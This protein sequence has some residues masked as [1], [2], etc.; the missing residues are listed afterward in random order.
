TG[1]VDGRVSF[2]LVADEQ[3]ALWCSEHRRWHQRLTIDHHDLR[4]ATIDRSN[5]ARARCAEV[6]GH[7]QRH[8]E[9]LHRRRS[10]RAPEA[11]ALGGFQRIAPRSTL[12][13]RCTHLLTIAPRTCGNCSD[14]LPVDR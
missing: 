1:R 10:A 13:A 5:R 3:R 6:D 7:V 14:P 2:G 11:T 4:F 8:P 12:K 9:L